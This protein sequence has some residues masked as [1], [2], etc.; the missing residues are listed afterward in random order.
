MSRFN[1]HEIYCTDQISDRTF[2]CNVPS[3]SEG[4]IRWQKFVETQ[5]PD[6]Y[7]P[8]APDP[9]FYPHSLSPSASP[10]STPDP[11]DH[12]RDI[13][14]AFDLLNRILEPRSVNRLTPEQALGHEFLREHDKDDNDYVPHPLGQG[15]CGSLHKL[16]EVGE[17]IVK[18]FLPRTKGDGSQVWVQQNRIVSSGQGIAIGTSPCEFHKDLPRK[19]NGEVNVNILDVIP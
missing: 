7:T 17:H 15:A 13:T 8:V 3:V 5:N 16:D 12:Q 1:F 10:P 4:G 2:I 6:L 9:R 11:E 18:V 19:E 14:E